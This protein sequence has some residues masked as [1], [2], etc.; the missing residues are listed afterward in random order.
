MALLQQYYQ[1]TRKY[2]LT[3]FCSITLT[4]FSLPACYAQEVN[5]KMVP[6]FIYNFTK[7]IE[8][9]DNGRNEFII[10]IVGNTSIEHFE[11]MTKSNTIKGQKISLKRM[12]SVNDIGNCQMIYVPTTELN[13]L[14]E[15][16]EAC[17][18]KS[19]LLVSCKAGLI[20]K[21]VDIGL[22][23]DE[24][25]GFKTKF[26]INRGKMEKQGLKISK[27]L[28]SLAYTVIDSK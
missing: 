8:W 7:Y 15:Y 4:L 6:V 14:K 23:I 13:H 18:D 2:I 21:G 10:G 11:K 20:R 17:K 16:V 19:T 3:L 25:D 12:N 5:E 28:L 9:P 26:E 22:F 27:E 1:V 24:E